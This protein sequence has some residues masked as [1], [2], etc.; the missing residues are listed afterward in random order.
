[1]PVD[2]GSSFLEF[3]ADDA[4]TGFRLQRLEVFNWGTFH[5]RVWS[6]HP[7]GRNCLLTGDIGSGKSTL[8]DAVTAL[9][10]P[11]NRIAF[12]KAA[13]ADFKERSLRSYVLGYHRT[14]RSADGIGAAKPV[15]LRDPNSFSVLLA[16]FHNGGFDQTISLACLLWMKDPHGQPTRFYVG[17]ERS[18][19]IAADFADFDS[20]INKLRRR[21][22]LSDASLFDSFPEY[23]AW[24]RRR[25]GIENEQAL[26][27]FHQ[28]VSMK[29]VGNLTDFVRDHMLEPFDVESRIAALIHHFDDLSRAHTAVLR[30][31]RQVSLLEPIIAEND[32][33][34]ALK[35]ESDELR[36]AR[37]LLQPYFATLKLRLL[38]ARS[39]TLAGDLDRQQ[40]R[41]DEV[42]D[43]L[44]AL[45]R[46]E[47]SLNRQISANGGDRIT[48]LKAR[49][50]ELGG[51]RDRRKQK[52][53]R[54][55]S[56]VKQLGETEA[57]DASTF[58]NQHDR[59]SD[60]KAS[61]EDAC[62]TLE[63]RITEDSFE[64]R[65]L[66]EELNE[67]K[68]EIESLAARRSNIPSSH[69]A[70]RA[71]L[72]AAISVSP[73]KMPFA[74]ELL[75]VRPEESDWEGAAE[76]LLRGL[77]LSLLVPDAH[78]SSVVEW[79]D[80]VNL[81]GK[82]V[83]FRIRQTRREEPSRPHPDSIIRKL[84]I[85]P[86]SEFYS[87][88][89]MELARRF[90]AACCSTNEQF[91]RE[92]RAITNAGQIKMPGE[93]HEKDD[94]HRL[95]D[96]SRYVLGW[97]NEAKIEALQREKSEVEQ[98]GAKIVS[99]LQKA[100]G[101]KKRLRDRV[102]LLSKLEEYRDFREIDWE[103]IA[104][105]IST[106]EDERQQ[107]ENSSDI[108]R[109][110]NDRLRVVAKAIGDGEAKQQEESGK[111]GAIQDRIKNTNTLIDTTRTSIAQADSEILQ[112]ESAR[113]ESLHQ[114][115]LGEHTLTVESCDARERDV[116]QWLQNRIDSK[117]GPPK[118]FEIDLSSKWWSSAGNLYL[119]RARWTLWSNLQENFVTSYRVFART[120]SLALKSVS[121]N[122][123]TRTRSVKLPILMP[124]STNN[125]K[126]FGNGLLEL[127]SP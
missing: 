87:W 77:G 54:Y 7:E 15:G 109:E 120:I 6:L 33:H 81:N 63:N 31:K 72:C 32:R 51:E 14:E 12:N 84:S 104:V 103:T 124:T 64:M 89:E 39:S 30:A 41:C 27:L 20:D 35:S 93:R 34:E 82:L 127:I 99:R 92:T 19:S 114:D 88:I 40:R 22:R 16:V 55:S 47:A 91:R 44:T 56:L 26:D 24:F 8:V 110:L 111:L 71:A 74:G 75:Q 49:I 18:L 28:T 102:E 78:Y 4:L 108:L 90:D 9:L 96:R 46:D 119:K 5:G 37:D 68:A 65:K 3:A 57:H 80:R 117:S 25:F 53:E 11:P 61:V 62:T 101:E 23:C 122:Y 36:K 116:R 58:A 17:A 105:E 38:E 107:L 60:L 13:G 43:T 113:L 69:V 85:R 2:P 29:S 86:D 125:A 73:D 45:R 66:Q 97:S 59:I 118:Q 98:K 100:D 1:M 121:K 112:Q 50:G 70:I 67:L 83:Y 10:V 42:G 94:S 115:A 123:S 76:R 79:V 52:S 21:L 95:D 106:L 48:E 126:R